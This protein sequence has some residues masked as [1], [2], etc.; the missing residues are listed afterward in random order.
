[1]G[2]TAP[3]EKLS[4]PESGKDG[5]TY[6]VDNEAASKV[7]RAL[8]EAKLLAG[9]EALLRSF[10]EAQ[11]AQAVA[12][13]AGEQEEQSN[14][15]SSNKDRSTT[16]EAAV[17]GVTATQDESPKSWKEMTQDGKWEHVRQLPCF[18]SEHA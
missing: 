8:Q 7:E 5:A 18:S 3:L 9:Q 12:G 2:A 6:P 16:A 17:A 4:A 13:D 14:K 11:E 15:R 1:M 10:K